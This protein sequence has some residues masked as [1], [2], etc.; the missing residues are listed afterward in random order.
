MRDGCK[1]WHYAAESVG[2][3]ARGRL[4]VSQWVTVQRGGLVRPS[5]TAW[6][7]ASNLCVRRR[8]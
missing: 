2:G 6:D 1:E 8:A 7:G 4:P 3:G 5:E